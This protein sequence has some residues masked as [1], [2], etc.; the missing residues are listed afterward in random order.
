MS[1]E[2]WDE[3]ARSRDFHQLMDDDGGILDGA[4]VPD[5]GDD[6]LLGLYRTMVGTRTTRRHDVEPPTER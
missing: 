5:L 4:D 2:T 3:A 6:E 1:E